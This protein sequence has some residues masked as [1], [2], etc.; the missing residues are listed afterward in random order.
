MQLAKL[1]SQFLEFMGTKNIPNVNLLGLVLREWLPGSFSSSEFPVTIIFG[2]RF[3][4]WKVKYSFSLQ[5]L[6]NPYGSFFFCFLFL[7]A[8]PWLLL[9]TL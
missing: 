4:L 1:R 6:T 8:P 2:F 5:H 3:F 7:F 9:F